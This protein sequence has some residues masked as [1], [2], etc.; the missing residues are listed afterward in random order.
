MMIKQTCLHF[1]QFYNVLSNTMPTDELAGIHLHIE[2]CKRCAEQLSFMT[3]MY[4]SM[5]GSKQNK[6]EK[7]EAHLSESIKERYFQQ[8]LS[9]PDIDRVHHHLANCHECF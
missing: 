3:T 8:N 7:Y 2:S 9:E 5:Q 6:A 1:S 4:N